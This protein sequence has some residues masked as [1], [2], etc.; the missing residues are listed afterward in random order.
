MAVRKAARASRSTRLYAS[1]D[2][3]ADR[4]RLHTHRVV[5]RMLRHAAQWGVVHANVASMVDAPRVKA[6]EIEILTAQQV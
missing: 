3:V 6:E 4:T 5:H 2:G 1:M